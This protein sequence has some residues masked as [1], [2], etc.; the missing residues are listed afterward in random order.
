[1]SLIMIRSLQQLL[2][3]LFSSE[4]RRGRVMGAMKTQVRRSAE[5]AAAA[6]PNLRGERGEEGALGPALRT[7]IIAC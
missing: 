1:M 3:P 7:R 5:A 2:E 6:K 4:A